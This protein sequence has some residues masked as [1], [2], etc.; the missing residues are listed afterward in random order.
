MPTLYVI[1]TP[2]GNLEDITLRALRVLKEV[3]LIAAEDTRVTRR[4]LSH[5]DIHTRMF[6]YNDNNRVARMPKLLS[7]LEIMDVALVSD[8]GM[9]GVNDP[10]HQLVQ[11][12]REAGFGVVPVP[13]PSAVTTA[14]SVAGIPLQQFTYLGFLP[15]RKAARLKLLESV[16]EAERPLVILETPHRL[17]AALA[18]LREAL[19]NRQISVCRELTKLHEEV[20]RGAISE[21]IEH[22]TAPRGEITLVVE[23]ADPTPKDDA[24]SEA[25]AQRMLHVLRGQDAGSRD[26]VSAVME[27]TG[28]ARN[29]VYALWVASEKGVDIKRR[30]TK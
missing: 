19:G 12:A 1:G 13:G 8:A 28:L 10:G 17:R 18:D 14:I 27:A 15:R 9:P 23:G 11:A 24:A 26:A 4:L 22:F 25:T 5:F 29:R 7:E 30:T 20:F 16:A 3:G 6:S 21:A 2:I